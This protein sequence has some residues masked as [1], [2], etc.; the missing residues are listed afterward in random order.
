MGHK[1]IIINGQNDIN[2]EMNYL[3]QNKGRIMH[4][5]EISTVCAYTPSHNEIIKSETF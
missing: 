3:H 1:V 4:E 5:L 2:S